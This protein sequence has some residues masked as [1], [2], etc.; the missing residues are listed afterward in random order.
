VNQGAL[1]PD[2]PELRA[3]I[4]VLVWPSPEFSIPTIPADLLIILNSSKPI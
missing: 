4:Y 2:R 1:A 3:A